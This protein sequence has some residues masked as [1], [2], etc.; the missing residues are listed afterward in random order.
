M[1]FKCQ[2]KEK[3]EPL[4]D[5]MSHDCSSHGERDGREK[6]DG[7]MDRGQIIPPVV[8]NVLQDCNLTVVSH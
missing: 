2:I 6:R 1:L 5:L 8:V 4:S 3:S 7:E